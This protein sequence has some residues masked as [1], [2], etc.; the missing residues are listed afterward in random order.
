MSGADLRR[1]VAILP[2]ELRDKADLTFD[3]VIVSIRK[4]A[5]PELVFQKCTWFSTYRIHHRRARRFRD[6]RCFILGDAAHVHS[7]VGAQGMNT[8]LQDAYNLGWKLA[9]VVAGT[10]NARLLDSYEAERIPVAERLLSTTDRAFSVAVSNNAFAGFFRTRMLARMVA[11]AMHFEAVRKFAFMTIAQTGI[12]YRAS[13]LS[14]TLHG[15][16]EA[17]PRA[18]DRFPWLRLKL[19]AG[20]PVEDMYEK[21]NDTKFNLILIGQSSAHANLPGFGGHLLVHTE[22]NDLANESRTGARAYPIAFVLFAAA[23]WLCRTRRRFL[24][25]RSDGALGRRTSADRHW[26][27]VNGEHVALGD[28]SHA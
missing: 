4:Q 26:Q 18:G 24:R 1:I 12:S 9:L 16:P 5:G 20:G 27:R 19:A 2:R 8:G 13:P 15:V 3:D 21:L 6:R 23:G 7:P 22:P 25:R 10:A 11:F 14:Q 28:N 17:A